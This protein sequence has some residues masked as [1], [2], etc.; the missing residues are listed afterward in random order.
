MSTL[1]LSQSATKTRVGDLAANDGHHIK[2]VSLKMLE[3]AEKLES[4]NKERH[5]LEVENKGTLI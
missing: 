4:L 2:T 1:E 3:I 5:V